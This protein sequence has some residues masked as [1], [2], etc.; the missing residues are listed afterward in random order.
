MKKGRIA[1]LGD[2][3]TYGYNPYN[4]FGDPYDTPWPKALEMLLGEPVINL[5][6]NG[7]E[8]PHRE[9]DFYWLRRNLT[10]HLPLDWMTIMLGS[11]DLLNLQGRDL[12]RIGKR[13]E[14]LLDYFQDL[15]SDTKLLLLA[16]PQ[17]TGMEA[18][19]NPACQKLT[20]FYCQLAEDRGILFADPK[21]W[22]LK[23]AG[24]GVHLD[25]GSHILLAEKIAEIIN[26][27]N[28]S[29]ELK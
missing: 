27:M 22:K 10:Q 29:K 14:D 17:M 1:C 4:Y 25:E 15:L 18:H 11:N 28:E 24:D 20:D 8:I 26:A 12:A 3:N 23:I 9:R 21:E 16:P 6:E 19:L 2:S 7:A 13:M 5:G